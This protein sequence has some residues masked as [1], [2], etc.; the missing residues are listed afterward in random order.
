M[1]SKTKGADCA[2]AHQCTQGPQH[3]CTAC[4]Y[5]ESCHAQYCD[6]GG[7]LGTVLH[8]LKSAGQV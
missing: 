4:S 7:Y 5:A 3:L 6:D 2:R 8:F 1:Y